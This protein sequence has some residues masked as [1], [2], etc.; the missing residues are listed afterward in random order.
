[1]TPINST[2]GTFT[3]S[4]QY[5]ADL[6]RLGVATYKILPSKFIV[7]GS[8]CPNMDRINSQIDLVRTKPGATDRNIQD[9]VK[10][11]LWEG[12]DDYCGL[13]TGALVCGDICFL[14]TDTSNGYTF[15]ETYVA[16]NGQDKT[17]VFTER[18][19]SISAGTEVVKAGTSG[20]G[21]KMFTFWNI[22]L[23]YDMHNTTN[24]G[25]T[26]VV[27]DQV[28][29]LYSLGQGQ[30]LL[31][32]G[33]SLYGTGTS[34]AVRILTRFAYDGSRDN[35]SVSTDSRVTGITQI[36]SELGDITA[37]LRNI[38]STKYKD[39]TYVKQYLDN[40]KNTRTV[41]IPYISDDGKWWMVNG[42]AVAKFEANPTGTGTC[43]C[44]EIDD[45]EVN[46]IIRGIS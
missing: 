43:G 26:V 14:G 34:W 28:M 44:D 32:N 31:V 23:L 41:N 2:A 8:I 4:N 38:T 18:G 25:D 27:K 24:T 37:E 12:N 22:L 11:I 45:N 35:I 21:E 33:D 10:K 3:P 5:I 19:K 30:T 13:R 36:L 15:T 42:K 17:P 39:L 7:Y 6:G 20:Y 40:F 9:N 1:M 29:G 16:V 46:E